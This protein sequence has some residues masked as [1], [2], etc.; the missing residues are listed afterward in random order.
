MKKFNL[1]IFSFTAALLM[2]V[3]FVNTSLG[4]ALGDYRTVATG[5]WNTLAIWEVC[6]VAGTPGTWAAA[7]HTPTNADNVIT[8]LNTHTVTV[9]ADV[10]VDQV[11]VDAGGQ[12]TVNSGVTLIYAGSG[13]IVVSGTLQVDGTFSDP[14]IVTII[15]GGAVYVS[16]S[17]STSGNGKMTVNSGAN[18]TLT[19]TGSVAISSVSTLNISGTLTMSGSSNISVVRGNGGSV[20]TLNSGGLI[21][22][23]GTSTF[24]NNSG[25]SGRTFSFNSGSTLRMGPDA[26]LNGNGEFDINSGATFEIGSTDGITL[27]GATGNVQTTSTRLFSTGA[28]YTYNGTA[29]QVTGNGLSGAAKL[30]INNAAGV[31]LSRALTTLNTLTIGDVTANSLFADG[32]YAITTTGTLNLTSGTYRLGIA[33][34]A[35]TFPSFTIRN[36]SAGTTVEYAAGVAQSVSNLP[37]YANLTFSGAS[38]KTASGNLTVNENLTISA[39]TLSAGT[40]THNVKGNWTNNGTFTAGTSTVIFSGSALQSIAGSSSTT[41][42]NLTIS[43]SAGITFSGSVGATVNGTLTLTSGNITTGA[44]TLIVSNNAI[45]AVSHTSGQVVGNLQR[46]IAGSGSPTYTFDVGTATSYTPVDVAF[47]TLSGAGNLTV[48]VVSGQNPNSGSPVNTA[49]DVDLYWNLTNAGVTFTNYALTFHY[50]AGDIIGGANQSNFIVGKYTSS[51]TS[52]TPVTNAGFGPYTT[53]VT[54]L[55]DFGDF[56]VGEGACNDPTNGGTIA[57]DQNGCSPFNPALIT[58]SALPTRL[59]RNAGIQMAGINYRQR[60][61]L[62]GYCQ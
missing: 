53:Q 3:L 19:G 29:A 57:T 58:S 56:V 26:L 40:Y 2:L 42:N 25:A 14:N 24:S 4:A 51:W 39:G 59:H 43:N 18:L 8:I 41:F 48:K 36:I 55:T 47:T 9:T 10:T 21:A 44:N 17:L 28:N 46:A 32:G 5:N 50:N 33:G 22:M 62:F 31:T 54:G 37:T 61:W 7:A 16:G 60:L 23:S 35:T 20:G 11:V 1:S 30:K 52:P 38:T 15:N 6:T 27:T 34:T 45:G 49:K 13:E 12:I